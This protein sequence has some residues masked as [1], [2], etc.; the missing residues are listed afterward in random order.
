M[1]AKKNWNALL[2]LYDRWEKYR[3][4]PEVSAPIRMK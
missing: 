4:K 1:N 3:W 2:V